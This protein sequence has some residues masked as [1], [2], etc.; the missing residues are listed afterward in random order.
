MDEKRFVPLLVTLHY[1]FFLLVIMILVIGQIRITSLI[2]NS[3][4]SHKK[5]LYCR[6][7][8]VMWLR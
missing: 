1:K 6:I 7:Q 8:L 2:Q 4:S 3:A 5:K